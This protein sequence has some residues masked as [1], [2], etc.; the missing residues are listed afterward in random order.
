MLNLAQMFLNL[1]KMLESKPK[2]FNQNFKTQ[3]PPPLE[4]S[5]NKFY[6]FK[7]GTKG[8]LK[9]KKV[10]NIGNNPQSSIYFLE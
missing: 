9:M 3:T 5:T 8:S 1:K 2:G 10:L 7:I 6:S 4:Q